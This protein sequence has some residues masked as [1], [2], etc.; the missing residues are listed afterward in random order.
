MP[1]EIF[2]PA[3]AGEGQPAAAGASNEQNAMSDGSSEGE[4]DEGDSGEMDGAE[5][6]DLGRDG[7]QHSAGLRNQ[8]GDG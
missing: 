8:Q 2:G 6:M 7:A 3:G 5:D 4:E 1:E